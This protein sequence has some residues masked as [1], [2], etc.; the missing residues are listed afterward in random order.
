MAVLGTCVKI[1]ALGNVREVVIWDAVLNA[2]VVQVVVIKVALEGAGA[3]V[4]HLAH[5]NV[6]TI[7]YSDV[8]IVVGVTVALVAVKII[9]E[10]HV[11]VDARARVK[12]IAK[13]H[14]KAIAHKL[15][16]LVVETHAAMIVLIDVLDNALGV[17]LGVKEIVADLVIIHVVDLLVN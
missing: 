1:H 10:P 14:A 16:L 7:V 11:Q 8:K 9:A 3:Y 15:V 5:H 6:L 2:P 12:D 17:V 13:A 4:Q